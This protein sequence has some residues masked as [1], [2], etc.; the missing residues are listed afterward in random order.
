VPSGSPD[1]VSGSGEPPLGD[2]DAS[3]SGG[4]IADSVVLVV[5]V[6][7]VVVLVAAGSDLPPV[8]AASVAAAAIM[9]ARGIRTSSRKDCAIA[10][11][12]GNVAGRRVQRCAAALNDGGFKGG[13]A[14]AQQVG[15]ECPP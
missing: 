12:N 7:E 8:Q 4:T 14:N 3:V 15:R 11:P 10:V 1:A 6:N 5:V 13:G 2:P 9:M